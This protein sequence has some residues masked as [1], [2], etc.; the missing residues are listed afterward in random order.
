MRALRVFSAALLIGLAACSSD[1][2]AVT[3][4]STTPTTTAPNKAASVAST[5][6]V[7]VAGSQGSSSTTSSVATSAPA[8][9]CPT[10]P[11]LDP[12]VKGDPAVI[13]D[14]DG[15]GK[16]DSV[17]V[18]TYSK[19][20]TPGSWAIH[21]ELGAGGGADAPIVE[22]GEGFAMP[23]FLGATY[24][25]EKK[26]PKVLMIQNAAPPNS[27][28]VALF[29]FL[30]C[31]IKLVTEPETGVPSGFNVSDKS[32]VYCVDSGSAQRL[33]D[34]IVGPKN[35]SGTWPTKVLTYEVVA[36]KLTLVGNAVDT[37]EAAISTHA[38][39]LDCPGV[40][41]PALAP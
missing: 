6:S 14:V 25:G 4:T 11:A 15:D 12:I 40:I 10:V 32:G 20:G 27:A 39:V 13:A 31:A 18:Y 30:D 23:K 37:G 41:A 5:A 1:P 28:G 19:V 24:V 33:L 35:S 29:Q 7:T 22:Q 17:R 38:G 36:G 9:A 34:V 2:Q 26:G 21:I 3:T 16:D 8:P